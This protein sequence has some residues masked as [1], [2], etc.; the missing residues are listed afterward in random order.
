MCT[1]AE[2]A[3]ISAAAA[4]GGAAINTST[5]NKAIAEANNQN[6]IRMD[7]E[8]KARNEEVA[9]QAGMEATSA[10]QVTQ[11]LL[12]A[13]P[14]GVAETV[15]A[16]AADPMNQIVQSAAIHN[17]PALQ[18]Q[19]Q[20]V[21]V[22]AAIDEKVSGRLA[23]TKEMLKNMAILSGQGT[24]TAGIGDLI[25]RSGSEIQTI[26]SKR[27]GSLGA[28]QLETAIPA[29]DVTKSKSM[30]GDLLMM[31]G[32]AGG[33]YGGQM[34]GAAGAPLFTNP[35]ARKALPIT[36]VGDIMAGGLY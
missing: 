27:R 28:S 12:G 20:N 36:S 23:R 33:S 5:Q 26:G 11:A 10:E 1:G 17:V 32:A 24:A 21:D 14:A 34:A 22:T 15:A 6:R 19:V 31:A 7:I 3:L 18:G 9:R 35:F 4:G 13:D 30:L 25:G 8:R 2:I 16:Q 29:A